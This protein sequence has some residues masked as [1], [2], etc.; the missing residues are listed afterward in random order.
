MRPLVT[1]LLAVASLLFITGIVIA[2]EERGDVSLPDEA[3]AI[4]GADASQADAGTAE[5]ALPRYARLDAADLQAAIAV[6]QPDDS[7]LPLAIN[8][9]SSTE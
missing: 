5:D 3:I 6:Q 9:F 2:S 8:T 1:L 4:W 7:S